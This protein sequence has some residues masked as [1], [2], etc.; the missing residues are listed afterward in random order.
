MHVLAIFKSLA[1]FVVIFLLWNTRSQT[2][3]VTQ[4]RKMT[5]DPEIAKLSGTISD[6]RSKNGRSL[7]KIVDKHGRF[8]WA[9]VREEMIQVGD[10]MSF[11]MTVAHHHYY[12]EDF[13]LSLPECYLVNVFEVYPAEKGLA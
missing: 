3:G 2:R 11:E 1:I 8:F 4:A 13:G 6:V 7:V 10:H 5:T 12:V 9:I